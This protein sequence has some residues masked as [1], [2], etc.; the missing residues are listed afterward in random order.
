M[1]RDYDKGTHPSGDGAYPLAVGDVLWTRRQRIQRDSGLARGPQRPPQAA[2]RHEARR[3]LT[4]RADSG[5][6]RSSSHAYGRRRSP[7]AVG[8]QKAPRSRGAARV[9]GQGKG[10]AV[11]LVE[12]EN[13]QK[14]SEL[15][16]SDQS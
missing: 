5:E 7:I 13:N 4:H 12:V 8:G 3:W 10:S 14:S 11:F 9:V 6:G 15:G 2:Q 1:G 16:R